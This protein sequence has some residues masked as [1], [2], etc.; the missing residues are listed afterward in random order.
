[1][2]KQNFKPIGNSANT[3]E[4]L[5]LGKTL[6]FYINCFTWTDMW[7]ESTSS[8]GLHSAMISCWKCLTF[9]HMLTHMFNV[10]SVI[11]NDFECVLICWWLI[12]FE[13]VSQWGQVVE[14][15]FSSANFHSC[16]KLFPSL[17]AELY[18]M[19]VLCSWYITTLGFTAQSRKFE[20]FINTHWNI[21]WGRVF[22]TPL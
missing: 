5:V 13:I 6:N 3:T 12:L 14:M 21:K 8:T 19:K 16:W 9:T 22:I 7:N 15:K 20:K 4:F 1:M 17:P 10:F 2:E 18:I 11:K